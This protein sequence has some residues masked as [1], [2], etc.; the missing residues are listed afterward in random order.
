MALSLFLLHW[1]LWCVQIHQDLNAWHT[2]QQF[3]LWKCLWKDG[4]WPLDALSG[5]SQCSHRVN[6]PV[7]QGL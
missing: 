7:F 6:P 2:A 4:M 1:A 5:I 3:H